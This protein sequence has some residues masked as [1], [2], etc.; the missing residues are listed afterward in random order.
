MNI[1]YL[2]A[3]CFHGANVHLGNAL[4]TVQD[5]VDS[6]LIKMEENPQNVGVQADGCYKLSISGQKTGPVLKAMADAVVNNIDKA[7]VF[8]TC[9][10]SI[11]GMIV[12]NLDKTLLV[13]KLSP[14]LTTA[15]I[16]G[17]KKYS[18]EPKVLSKTLEH[19]AGLHSGES[20]K[21]YT[22]DI[23]KLGG[24]D[25]L[26]NAV[27][28]YPSD[29]SV[30]MSAWRGFSDHSHTDLG[31]VIIANYGGPLKGIEW[32][33]Q[34]LRAHPE[35]HFGISGDGL[36]CH[37]EIM[38]V[39][40]GLLSVDK[41]NVYGQA[42]MKEGLIDLV[43]HA[44]QVDSDLRGTQHVNCE[45]INGLLRHHPS[46]KSTLTKGP[47]SIMDLTI[48]A[49]QRFHDDD[50]TPWG[51]NTIGQSYPVIPPCI[52]V[53]KAIASSDTG[54]E[55]IQKTPILEVLRSVRPDMQPQAKQL[56]NMVAKH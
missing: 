12:F 4:A 20:S 39:V 46:L 54:L 25:I 8:V 55:A 45:V 14:N 48:R 24:F 21:F 19:I 47:Q 18:N 9:A 22:N 5:P 52:D 49:I 17:L 29:G 40:N 50:P 1:I 30:Q 27:D 42:L 2:F 56:A 11:V 10:G 51:A 26:H 44:M 23:F 6:T 16:A 37:Y 53:L 13:H 28:K 7:D 32:L 38:Q 15:L 36:D 3:L 33:M 35:P 41:Y 34:K 31:A 43:S